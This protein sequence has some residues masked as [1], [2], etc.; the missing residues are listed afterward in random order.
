LSELIK[1][2]VI[3]LYNN[4][5]NEGIR[6]IKDIISDAIESSPV[7]INFNV[8]ETRYKDEIP[9]NDYD[10]FI[11]SGGPGSPFEGEGTK[12]EKNYF[13]LLDG[14]WNF[15]RDNNEKKKYIFFI[16][17]SF[18]MMSRFFN[19]G[20]VSKRDQKSFGV[21]PFSK[22]DIGKKD[23][24]LNDLPDPFYAADIRQWQ[25]TEANDNVLND[26]GAEILSYEI[27]LVQNEN[28]KAMTAIRIS[29]E[30]IG[31]QF[32]P[33]ADPESMLYHFKQDERKQQVTEQFGIEKYNEMISW[34]E[35]DEKIK[36]TR[37]TILP[38]FLN[39]AVTELNSIYSE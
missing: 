29:N 8:F 20:K 2:A 4:E 12:W 9:G 6:C 10:I 34:L 7:K 30:I 36:L 24:L 1:I 18:Q 13:N 26:L 16:C 17:H 25:V 38:G 14:I 35:D 33:E 27:P 22:T 23:N 3:D 31:T 5:R 15:N 28:E 32:H 19:L 11:S 21:L 39:K 37:K